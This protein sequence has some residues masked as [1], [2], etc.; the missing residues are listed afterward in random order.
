M[1]LVFLMID[2]MIY[3]SGRKY[4]NSIPGFGRKNYFFYWR[5]LLKKCMFILAQFT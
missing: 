5:D 1:F 3:K 2:L 4:L